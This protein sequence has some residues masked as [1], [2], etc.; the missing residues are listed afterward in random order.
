MSLGLSSLAWY[1]LNFYGIFFLTAGESETLKAWLDIWWIF[2]GS[3]FSQ[4]VSLRL[5][6]PGFIFA[7]FL[8]DL[9]SHRMWVWDSQSLAWYLLNFYGILFLTGGES[10]SLV[11][12]LLNFHMIL[13]SCFLQAVSLK[14]NALHYCKILS[15]SLQL[16]CLYSIYN[17]L[18][19]FF[20]FT[21]F[22][23]R[24]SVTFT[25]SPLYSNHSWY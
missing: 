9:V 10:Q 16:V 3:C 5:S 24:L 12:Y 2:M 18:N 19:I 14:F 17:N 6:K 13:G 22:V 8:W 25:F 15:P 21:F 1:L 4:W 20:L 7:E 11:W 23:S